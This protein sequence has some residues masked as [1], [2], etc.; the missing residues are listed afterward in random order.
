MRSFSSVFLDRAGS[1]TCRSYLRKLTR[2]NTSLRIPARSQGTS[3]CRN[4]CPGECF[5]IFKGSSLAHFTAA[6]C[7]SC[8]S[9]LSPLFNA[10]WSLLKPAARFCLNVEGGK[11][12]RWIRAKP[13]PQ[14]PARRTHPVSLPSGW[15]PERTLPAS[16]PHESPI[17]R[18]QW[19]ANPLFVQSVIPA[20]IHSRTETR[21]PREKLIFL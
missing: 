7:F 8:L 12:R 11:R 4:A 17:K 18:P 6:G 9:G 15:Y 10:H 13:S 14:R 21:A 5:S 20:C 3:A 1:C 2:M 19:R 16:Q